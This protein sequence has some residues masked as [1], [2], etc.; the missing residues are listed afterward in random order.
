ME[1]IQR[2]DGECKDHKWETPT[3]REEIDCS[4]T[5]VKQQGVFCEAGPL[6]V[7]VSKLH[8]P[9]D[10]KFVPE[11]PAPQ[12]V[13]SSGETIVQGSAVRVQLIGL[14]SDVGQMF[15]IGKMSGAW[16]G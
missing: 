16:F 5:N 8:L 1:A 10:M 12:F 11:A 9:P 2:R 6:V 14:R 4:V 15:A 13:N 3:D 7:F